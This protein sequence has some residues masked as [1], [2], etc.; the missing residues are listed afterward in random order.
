M[1]SMIGFAV[2]VLLCL[3][4]HMTTPDESIATPASTKAVAR[5]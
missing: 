4:T 1:C 5:V 3:K 2:A